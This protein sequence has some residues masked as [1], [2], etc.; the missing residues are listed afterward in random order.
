[1]QIGHS[2]T[3]RQGQQQ[4][5]WAMPWPA[6][7]TI[8]SG[9]LQFFGGE[10][11]NAANARQA[12]QQMAF[13]AAM[14]ENQA[15]FAREMSERQF[16]QQI[17]GIGRQEAFGREMVGRQEAFQA[18][19]AREAMDFSE[20]MSSTAY[21]RATADMRAAGINPM[22]A[23][24]QGGASS[25][26][27]VS[28]PGASAS[29]G[30]VPGAGGGI[31]VA[32]GAAARFE[33]S[34]G[35]AIGSAF[36]GAKILGELELLGAQIQRVQA[37]TPYIQAGTGVRTVEAHQRA[38]ATATD[39]AREGLYRTQTVTER[40]RAPYVRAA[41]A[42]SSSQAV[43]NQQESFVRDTSGGNS[44]IGRVV[45]DLETM[46]RRYILGPLELAPVGRRGTPQIDGR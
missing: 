27:G 11:Q 38:Q 8:A 41:T 19:M 15:A 46:L 26:V 12:Q 5:G 30:G 13:Q 43:L 17:Y 14:A 4:G 1:M 28:A 44:V 3:A 37:E 24:S 21:Q 7:A 23:V 20:R 36:Q 29:V 45:A 35:M 18:G 39:V 6:I 22:L 33:N 32:P 40:E 31:S 10:R 34:L 42:L 25:P 9:A 16:Q 2:V